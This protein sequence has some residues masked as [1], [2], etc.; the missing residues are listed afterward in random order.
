MK[1][2]DRLPR[3]IL[4]A[5]VR[6]RIFE[7]IALVDCLEYRSALA[8]ELAV[9]VVH[10][11]VAIAHRPLQQ[12]GGAGEDADHGEPVFLNGAI[13]DRAYGGIQPGAIAAGSQHADAVV[14]QLEFAHP[15]P[16]PFSIRPRV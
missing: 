13:G 15:G 4:D 12:A 10:G 8:Q 14:L 1:A 2:F 6:H 5:A 11:Q 3:S 16:S 9:D 7:W